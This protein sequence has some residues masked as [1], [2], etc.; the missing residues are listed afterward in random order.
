MYEQYRKAVA[1]RVAVEPHN[2]V[3]IAD[4]FPDF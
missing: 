2:E 4:Y 1:Y 3:N